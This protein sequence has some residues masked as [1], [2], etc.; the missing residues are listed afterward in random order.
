M[1]P[2]SVR[3]EFQSM[4]EVT[5]A[6]LHVK[7]YGKHW[8]KNVLHADAIILGEKTA[9][10]DARILL[11][12]SE[13]SSPY[14][15]MGQVYFVRG[16]RGGGT[17][18]GRCD[19]LVDR[20]CRDEECFDNHVV[21]HTVARFISEFSRF[22]YCVVRVTLHTVVVSLVI[23]S[24]FVALTVSDY[25]DR[26]ADGELLRIFV[27]R[28][29]DDYGNACKLR[30]GDE[31][32]ATGSMRRFDDVTIQMD[33]TS[34]DVFEFKTAWCNNG[35]LSYNPAIDSS[36][37]IYQGYGP[38]R[39]LLFESLAVSADGDLV[40]ELQYSSRGDDGCVNGD[41]DDRPHWLHVRVR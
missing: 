39:E 15:E 41:D 33:A 40:H 38:R 13:Q 2:A 20:H 1:S 22:D 25:T 11:L 3:R 36:G 37:D 8:H 6:L 4:E 30:A 14:I 9:D 19:L 29:R 7:V 18:D 31:L 10:E 27:C 34:I 21:T 35:T 12:I 16:T 24:D 32:Y 26:D 23:A 17:P 5:D 28:S